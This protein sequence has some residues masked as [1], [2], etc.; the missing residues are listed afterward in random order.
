MT[1]DKLIK[2]KAKRILCFILS[3][4]LPIYMINFVFANSP[5]E[6]IITDARTYSEADIYKNHENSSKKIAITFDD[7]P[8]PQYTAQILDILKKYNI[9]ATFFV[10]GTNVVRYPELITREIDEG[11]EIG[12]HTYNH[13]Y[14]KN[15]RRG[16]ILNEIIDT[17]RAIFEAADYRPKHLRPPGGMYNKEVCLLAGRLDYDIIIWD[18]D[19]RDWAKTPTDKIV[20]NVLTNVKSGDIILFHDF[21]CGKSPTPEALEQ[22]IPK[23]LEQGY[24]FVTVSELIYTN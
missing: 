8:H 19:T 18:I 22:I 7:G 11:H 14:L 5:E 16:T 21:I 6:F 4:I 17:E 15:E 3:F 13:A 24:S 1:V 10:V 9:P 20:N 23:L 12:N 2:G